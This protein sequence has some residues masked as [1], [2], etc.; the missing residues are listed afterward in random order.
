MSVLRVAYIHVIGA[1]G[2]ASRSLF[3]VV[4]AFPAG[5]IEATFITQ[6]GTV[7]SYFSRLGRVV[8]AAGLTKFDNTR[9][10]Y[11]RG[12][13]WLVLLREIAYLPATLVA[14]RRAR[15][16]CGTVDIVHL[17]E[18]TG[19]LVLWLAR[20]WLKAS[21]AVVHVRSVARCDA[22]SWR[23]RWVNRMLRDEADAVIAIDENVRASLP[24]DLPVEVI[25]NAFSPAATGTADDALVRR[26]EALRP[27]SFKVGFVGNLL[28]V[29]GIHELV[30]AA[31]LTKEHGLDVE[32]VV[33]GDDAQRSGGIKARVLRWLGLEQN[34][35]AEVEA[36]L[37]RHGLR[38]RVHLIGFTADISTVY[39]AID[40]LCFPSHYDAPGRPIFEAA[41]FGVP[42]IV[43]VREPRV[44]TLVDGETGL[45]ISPRSASELAVAIERLAKDRVSCERMGRSARALAERNFDVRR[46]AGKLLDLY[47]RIV[48]GAQV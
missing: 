25:H 34:V 5:E 7:R 29:K 45:A 47:R 14:L 19:L 28:V 35:R 10:S 9:Y 20:R 8:E 38:D 48:R 16:A 33:V 3:E 22:A 37:D 27:D 15:K 46:N 4:R 26:L 2:G 6:R 18:F 11:Y 17:N 23:T 40:V 43:A 31:R 12:A 39:R 32:F 36:A 24:G 1:F 42:S 13:R 44:D 21:A 41:F 30:E